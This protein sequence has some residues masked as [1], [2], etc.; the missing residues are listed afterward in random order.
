MILASLVEMVEIT[1]K[2]IFK[3]VAIWH[4]QHWTTDNYGPL[5]ILVITD[6]FVI[7][8]LM[9]KFSAL[10]SYSFIIKQNLYAVP[11]Q[12]Y[13]VLKNRAINEDVSGEWYNNK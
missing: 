10:L 1:R 3:E 7:E 2:K 4:W 5:S 8:H 13:S 11:L 6:K 9:N 12:Y